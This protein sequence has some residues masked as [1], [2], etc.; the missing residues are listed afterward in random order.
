VS[1]AELLSC[2]DTFLTTLQL[3]KWYLLPEG[4]LKTFCDCP[5]KKNSSRINILIIT[6]KNDSNKDK[7]ILVFFIKD[8][9]CDF[10]N[11]LSAE[12]LSFLMFLLQPIYISHFKSFV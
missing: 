9:F 10:L 8:R 3:Y 5:P 12:F 4:V 1:I 6:C 11:S 2:D 7:F